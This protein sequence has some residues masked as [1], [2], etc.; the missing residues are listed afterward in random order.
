[1]STSDRRLKE[2]AATE[3]AAIR[4]RLRTGD[5]YPGDR[6]VVHVI[7]DTT[8]SDTFTVKQGRTLDFLSIP[9]V[10]LMGVLDAELEEHIRSHIAKYLRNP[11]LTVTP[12]VRLQFTGGISQPGWYQFRMDTQLSDAI[13]SVGGPTPTSELDKSEIHRSGRRLLDRGATAR[14][15]RTGKTI[16][17]IGLR[18]GDELRIAE[19]FVAGANRW[20]TI[21]P[22]VTSL[23]LAIRFGGRL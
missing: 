21:I 13:M 20:W 19:R 11:E 4:E 12:L 14:A 10:S 6:I 9:A 15:L 2:R 5:F 17:D 23:I 8:I 1:M 16:G 22:V 7:N 18:D 3:V